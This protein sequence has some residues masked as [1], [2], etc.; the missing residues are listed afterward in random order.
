MRRA[1]P[2]L[3]LAVLCVGLAAGCGGG[4]DGGEARVTEGTPIVLISV[5][6]LRSDRL[7]MYG[8][9]E[10]ETP[11][12]DALRRDSILFEHAFSPVPLTLPAHV[13]MLSGLL[14][15]DHGVRDNMGYQFEAGDHF[16]LPSRL[17]ERGYRTGAAVSAFVLRGTA[18]IA[19]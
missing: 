13:S 4:P 8:Y 19:E 11:A 6:T 17:R 9:G 15:P 1:S 12:L 14:P 18:G 5:D 10:V 7:P 2:A 16:W 3:G